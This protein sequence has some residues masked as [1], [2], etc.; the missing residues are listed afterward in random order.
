[1]ANVFIND[2]DKLQRVEK[3]KLDLNIETIHRIQCGAQVEH[4]DGGG[5]GMLEYYE[6]E[7]GE[8]KVDFLKR[9]Q[10][11]GW[12]YGISDELVIE[13]VFC[14]ACAISAYTNMRPLTLQQQDNLSERF[15]L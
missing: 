10:A 2:E 12:R 8:G 6:S 14:P 1:M 11:E 5:G 13:G 7:P 4:C 9:L 3:F 15:R